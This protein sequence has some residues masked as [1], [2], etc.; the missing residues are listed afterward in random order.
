LDPGR[1]QRD[2]VRVV[3]GRELVAT[4]VGAVPVEVA[5]VVVEDSLGVTAVEDQQAVGALI[6]RRQEVAV[7]RRQV[8]TPSLAA[9]ERE[10]RTSHAK[11]RVAIR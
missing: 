5:G 11:I 10:S 2:D 4:L 3:E 8:A 7:L 1:R 6:A 9:E